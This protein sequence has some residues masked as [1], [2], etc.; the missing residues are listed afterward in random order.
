MNEIKKKL[1]G[2]ERQKYEIIIISFYIF[3]FA[4]FFSKILKL[5]VF[6]YFDESIG[7]ILL[8]IYIL[9]GALLGNIKI[10]RKLII[11][12]LGCTVIVLI[13]IYSNIMYKIQPISAVIL[14]LIAFLKFFIALC[15]Y[16]TILKGIDIKNI[17]K[18]LA[19]HIKIISGIL[20]LLS[21][22]D[23]IFKIFDQT[24]RWGF[25]VI[26]LYYGHSTTFGDTCIFMMIFV[27]YL[28]KNIKYNKFY[29]IGLSI[30]SLFTIRFKI[31]ACVA[32]IYII[33][34]FTIKLNKKLN[35]GWGMMISSVGIL[36]AWRQIY[37]Y[38]FSEKLE[39]ARSALL[40]AS[41]KIASDYFPIGTGFG[42]FASS[43]SEKFYS[44]IYYKY[45][46]NIVYGLNGK[47]TTF[48]SDIFWPTL[49]GELGV[50]GTI[51]Y[52]LMLV[53]LFFQIQRLY[54]LNIEKYFVS[55]SIYIYMIA[56]TLSTSAFLSASGVMMGFGIS[57][58]L[59]SK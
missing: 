58:I 39:T 36:I 6:D 52:I 32:L 37:T 56:S 50:L 54:R 51:V 40:S 25:H 53:V 24:T 30:C 10:Y 28:R 48:I 18:K 55:L 29:I 47:N 49:F 42:T 35:I 23:S 45:N 22:L 11:Y 26:T 12:I 31:I 2:V 15:A 41:L 34:I 1:I 3:I 8:V 44:S 4:N 16:Y 17:E 13:G 19:F 20:I 9:N 38:F 43:A 46:L 27:I 59:A 21:V 7:C 57:I 33:Y 14:D 5:G